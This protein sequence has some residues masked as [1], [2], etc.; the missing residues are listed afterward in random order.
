MLLEIDPERPQPRQIEQ[1]VNCLKDGGIVAY[2]TDTTYGLGCSIFNKKGLERIYQVKQRDK[3]K[4]FSFICSDLAEV[5][6]YARLTNPAFKIMKRYLPGPYT[7]VLEASREVPD[8]LIT[9]QKTVG[10]RMPD[11]AICLSIVQGL[12]VPI[13]TTSA[14]LSGE[15]P[16]GDPLEINRLFGHA[17]DLVVDGGLLATDVSSVISLVGNHP[18]LLREGAGDLSW[19]AG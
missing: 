19:L 2:P 5:S 18:E 17:L 13:V 1:V 15:D 9:K 6:R 7:F 14:N 4:P 10:I 8:L 11:N 16:V 12:G 3:R